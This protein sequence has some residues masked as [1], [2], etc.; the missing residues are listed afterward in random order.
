MMHRSH[1]RGNTNPLYVMAAASLVVLAGLSFLL[2]RGVRRPAAVELTLFCAAGMR[3]PVERIAAD[4]ERAYG[5][6][7]QLNYGG[8]NTL[9]SQ[10][11]VGKIGDLYLAADDSY[12]KLARE[13]GL[14]AEEIPVALMRPVIAVQKGNPK[15][16]RAIAD[17]VRDGVRIALGNP[18]QAA[19]GKITRRLLT[20][21]GQW[22]DVENHTRATGVFKPT[23][24][25]VAM[26][27]DIGSVDA[28]ILW[29]AVVN[30]YPGLVAVRT[31]ELDAGTSHI[32]IGIMTASK[33]PT[34]A[35][36]FARYLTARD[37]GLKTFRELGYEPVDGDVWSETPQLTFFA[38]SVTRKAIEPTIKAFAAREGVE[39][40]TV[41][42]GCGI[43][44]GQ[45]KSIKR[46]QQSGFPD[47]YMACDVYYLDTVRDWFQDS[48]NVSD[49]AIVIVVQ[50]GNPKNIRSLSDLT[51]PGVRVA[52]GQPDQCTIGVLTRRLL[53]RQ[54]VYQT[55]FD[56]QN[57]V[58]ETAT[59]ALLVPTVTTGAADAALVY[60]T[61]TR[62]EADK[63][64][65]VPIDSTLAKAVQPFS[66]ARSSEHKY[67]GR[68]MFEAL[69]ASRAD[70]EA[71]GFVWRLD[72]PS[73]AGAAQPQQGAQER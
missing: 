38:G 1:R 7:V 27:I 63:L 53:E 49:T 28:G 9:L 10:I 61:D 19:I 52:I 3:K 29:D 62:A 14:V 37:R 2:L 40:N 67:L 13:K 6:R 30:Q 71:A 44:T 42:N 26:D 25:D 65:V 32:T 70:F 41:Y 57:I 60:A 31:P 50:E 58:T 22:A 54:G 36:R 68:R 69:A 21:S 51:R 5:T 43:L 59:S 66:I 4:Y 12:T 64:D 33:R 15:N 45:M 56:R 46:D 20:E 23:V 39:I 18:D 73:T 55:L 47:M 11:E 16:I 34:D 48:V 72:P 24:P 35:L 8:S 17:L